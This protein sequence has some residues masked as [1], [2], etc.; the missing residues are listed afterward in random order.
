M[1][2]AEVLTSAARPRCSDSPFGEEGPVMTM[3]MDLIWQDDC[4][5]EYRASCAECSY[6]SG[7][8]EDEETARASWFGHVCVRSGSPVRV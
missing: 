1:F 7:P 8:F 6:Q 2:T 3:K 4:E 5:I